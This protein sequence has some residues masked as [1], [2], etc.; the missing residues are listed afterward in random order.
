MKEKQMSN[1]IELD[2]S[3]KAF[4]ELNVI[5]SLAKAP[6][7]TEVFRKAL[8][9]YKWFLEIADAKSKVIIKKSNGESED[10]EFINS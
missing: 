6:S 7:N 5:R 4:E 8:S 9:V 1:I 10:V 3:D 2:F